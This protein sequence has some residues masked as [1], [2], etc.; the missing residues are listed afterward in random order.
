MKSS[1]RPILFGGM[2]AAPARWPFIAEERMEVFQASARHPPI[3]IVG[4]VHHFTAASPRPLMAC[5]RAFQSACAAS[6]SVVKN[7]RTA[8]ERYAVGRYT[9]SN[10]MAQRTLS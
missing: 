4:D 5:G 2:R 9:T 7:A 8:G 6:S 10:S 1:D 3:P